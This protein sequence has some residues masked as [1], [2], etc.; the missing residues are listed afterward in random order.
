MVSEQLVRDGTRQVIVTSHNPLVLD[1]LDLRNDKVRLFA[2]ER[3]HQGQSVVQRIE[4]SEELLAE[5]EQG[6]TLSR[7]WTQ[8]RLGG[9]PAL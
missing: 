4:V 9:V 1:G 6:M 5:A 3:N 8:G 2:V 7:L